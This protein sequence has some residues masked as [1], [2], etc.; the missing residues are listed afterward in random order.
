[1]KGHLNLWQQPHGRFANEIFHHAFA[2]R[3]AAHHDLELHTPQW[4]GQTF[5]GITDPPLEKR[6]PTIEDH[7]PRPEASP[8]WQSLADGRHLDEACIFGCFQYPT[9]LW[10]AEQR[11]IFRDTYKP[12][13]GVAGLLE[14]ELKRAMGAHRALVVV[15]VRRGDYVGNPLG[16]FYCTPVESYKLWLYDL[17]PLLDNPVLYVA[18]DD[19]GMP[20]EFA[21]FAQFRFPREHQF[22]DFWA[23][24]QADA[25][26]ISNSSFSFAAA[27]LNRK[28]DHPMTRPVLHGHTGAVVPTFVRPLS[29]GSMRAFDPWHDDILLDRYGPM[30][31]T[32]PHCGG[33]ER[34]LKNDRYCLWQRQPHVCARVA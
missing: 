17:W 26:A 27:M 6:L 23:M 9:G 21:D 11:A 4:L 18:S 33:A 34:I 3:L 22:V 15:H 29:D 12:V 7:D 16:M 13:E 30:T 5:F 14:S 8:L 19:P 25:L 32:C 24:M 2:R 20:S 10:P 1:M 31:D 28:H